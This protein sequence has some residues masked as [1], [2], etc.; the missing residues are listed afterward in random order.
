[1]HHCIRNKSVQSLNDQGLYS[2]SIEWFV[3]DEAFSPSYDSALSTPPLPPSTGD[4][5]KGWEREKTEGRREGWGVRGDKSY[6]RVKDWPSINHSILSDC[7]NNVQKYVIIFVTAQLQ[8]NSCLKMKNALWEL[9]QAIQ[10]GYHQPK[11]KQRKG[12]YSPQWGRTPIAGM[13]ELPLPT[14]RCSLLFLLCGFTVYVY[15]IVLSATMNCF[16]LP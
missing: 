15:N 13:P 4:T 10:P 8:Q 1:M 14:A 5:Q 11:T 12:S 9:E 3:K 2:E 6:D 16:E 7:T